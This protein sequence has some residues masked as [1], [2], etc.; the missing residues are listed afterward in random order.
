M[1]GE[2][3]FS[4]VG[5]EEIMENF[6]KSAKDAE[7]DDLTGVSASIMCGKRAKVGTSMFDVRLDIDKIL[8]CKST[9]I[10]EENN[11]EDGEY[12][13]AFIDYDDYE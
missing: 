3:P 8:S 6:Y 13:D 12:N 1:R 7:S 10:P 11:Y 5:F 9:T 4:K 2:K